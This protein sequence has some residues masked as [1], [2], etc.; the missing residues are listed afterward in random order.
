MEAKTQK[1]IPAWILEENEQ[2]DTEGT[3]TGEKLPA[4]KFEENKIVKFT[5]DFSE[6]FAEY[7]DTVNKAVKVIVPVEHQGIKKILWL[8]KRNPLYREIMQRAKEGKT[9]FKVLQTGNK[10]NTKYNLVEE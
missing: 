5:I 3:F 4:M 6:K 9:E 1:G 2:L 8:N 10:A 7:N